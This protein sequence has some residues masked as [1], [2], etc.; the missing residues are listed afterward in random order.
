MKSKLIIFVLLIISIF[1]MWKIGEWSSSLDPRLL[2]LPTQPALPTEARTI[3][4]TATL[5]VK[6][7]RTPGPSRTPRPT[8]TPLPTNTPTITLTVTPTTSATLPLQVTNLYK[9]AK[10]E[11]YDRFTVLDPMAWTYRGT[12]VTTENGILEYT[13]S[14]P[15]FTMRRSKTFS[16]GKGILLDFKYTK[17][18]AMFMMALSGGNSGLPNFR[19]FGIARDAETGYQKVTLVQGEDYQGITPAWTKFNNWY[20]LFLGISKKGELVLL[21]WEKDKPESW[22]YILRKP[23]GD[24]ARNFNWTFFV[25][26]QNEKNQVTVSV[27]DYFE[28]DLGE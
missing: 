1:I 14:N 17:E 28:L 18:P 20:R 22:A 5:E 2:T 10:I 24:N 9:N 21:L 16:E 6:S 8:E 23:I 4:P 12:N 25:K 26:G 27:S 3:T 19:Q 11:Y 15:P 7:T 13:T